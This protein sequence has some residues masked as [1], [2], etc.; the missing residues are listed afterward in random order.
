MEIDH[1]NYLHARLSVY[2][3]EKLQ[4][5]KAYSLFTKTNFSIIS[6]NDTFNIDS[7]PQE[8]PDTSLPTDR[9][10]S[11]VLQS[12]L[13]NL[14][15][16][17]LLFFTVE[18]EYII[19]TDLF[20]TIRKPSCREVIFSQACVKNSVHGGR[21]TP[22]WQT[23]HMVDIPPKQTPPCAHTPPGQTPPLGR[24]PQAFLFTQQICFK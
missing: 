23:T 6:S 14:H 21:C 8:A 13:T 22:P 3:H 18:E 9:K 20:V 19:Q 7:L 24:H 4:S 17:N 5:Y 15:Y 10:L 1:S 12:V 11:F 2:S 16:F